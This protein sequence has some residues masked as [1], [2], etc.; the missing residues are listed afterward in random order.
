MLQQIVEQ[1]V[2]VEE[3]VVVMDCTPSV[4]MMTNATTFAPN[5]WDVLY[6]NNGRNDPEAMLHYFEFMEDIPDKILYVANPY[7]PN[8]SIDDPDF[9]FNDFVY[10]NY[11]LIKQENIND[12]YDVRIYEI[13]QKNNF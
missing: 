8:L 6:Y 13:N 5:T 2:S 4:Y 12:I 1:N 10:E 3:K 9:L 11:H 7:K